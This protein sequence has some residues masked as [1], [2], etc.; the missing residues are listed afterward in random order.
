[1]EKNRI[2][3]FI[4][5]EFVAPTSGAYFDNYNPAK[6]EVYSYVADSDERDVNLAVEAATR[7]FPAWSKRP[8]SERAD[9]LRRLAT[10]ISENLE[11]LALAESIDNGKPLSLCRTLDI[12]RCSLNFTFFADIVSQFHG[13]TFPT[14]QRALNYTTYT[15]LG[16]VGTISPWNLPLYSFTWKIAPALVAGN[17]VVAKPSEVTPMTAFLLGRLV[18]AA[19]I[20]AGVLNIVQGTGSKVGSAIVKNPKI[21]AV[22][23]TGS[24][25]TG[26][27]IAEMA[28]PSFKKVSLEMGGKNANIIFADADFDRAVATTIRSSFLNQGQICLC[29]SRILVEKSIY[30]KFRDALVAKTKL[31]KVGNP[32]DEA[33]DQGALVSEAHMK[34]V[35]AHLEI[36]KSEGGKILCGGSRAKISGDNQNGYF[37]E[38]T[39]IEGLGPACRTN[40]EE[41]FGP[42]ATL[43]PFDTEAEAIEIANSTKY[44]LSASL[45]TTNSDRSHRV[46]NQLEAG[47]VW[48]NTWMLR[49]LRT[50]FG[51]VK[52]SGVGREGGV[53]ALAFFSEVKTICVG[54]S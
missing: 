22:S 49:D 3:N 50:P 6:G 40:Q 36:A 2:L 19:G 42:V 41:I 43:I 32:I 47:V 25:A 27:A 18:N 44:G 26:R 53:D 28:A 10:L 5:G 21:K 30:N 16:V 33:T 7:A 1:M 17:T 11:E 13:E 14:D 20:P 39:L 37:V 45:W 24:T 23:F 46:S 29:G 4:D 12:P 54:L 48:V 9:L 8:S 52:E 15:P 51:G 35:L 31:L 38:P 34:K